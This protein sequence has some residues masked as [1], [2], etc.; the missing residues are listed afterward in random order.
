MLAAWATPR[1]RLSPRTLGSGVLALL[2]WALFAALAPTLLGIDHP[3]LESIVKAG[4]HTALNLTLH[5]G[6]RY[7]LKTLAPIAAVCG[8][9]ALCAMRA[10]AQ[11][12][13][14]PPPRSRGAG[15]RARR[16]PRVPRSARGPARRAL[17]AARAVVSVAWPA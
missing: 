3:G 2:A 17:D 7:P 5:N 1:L 4:D 9:L 11:R 13:A 14:T 12:V 15:P 6:S 16:S 8:L 10:A